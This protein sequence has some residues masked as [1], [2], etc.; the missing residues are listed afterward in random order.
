MICVGLLVW[1]TAEVAGQRPA[2]KTAPEF[3]ALL[4][5][6]FDLHQK[7]QYLRALPLLRRA[8]KLEPHEYFVNLLLGIDLLRTGHGAESVAFLKEAA[9]ANS[10]EETPHEYLG[11]A[12]AAMGHFAEAFE[13]YARAV[14]LAPQ[15]P[16]AAVPS[17][18]FCLARYVA[19]ANRL[20]SSNAGLAAEYRL[21]AMAAPLNDGERVTLL[22]RAAS[23]D[24]G[25]PGL[26]SELALTDLMRGD[27]ATGR[28]HLQLAQEH[29]PND[30]RSW[31]AAAL[32]AAI[33][34]DWTLAS[35]RLDAIYERSPGMLVRAVTDWP[36][37]LHPAEA[38]AKAGPGSVFL[39]CSGEGKRA[40]TPEVL[41]D[42]LEPHANTKM[43]PSGTPPNVLFREQR[44][45]RLLSLPEPA[46]AETEAWLHRGVAFAEL[47]DCGH[48]IPAL[49]HGL[50]SHSDSA[51]DMLLLSVCYARQA[52]SIAS[53][54]QELGG[55]DASLHMMR[56][57]ILLRLHAD[58]SGALAEYQAA[59]ARHG[60]DPD[61]LQ[62]LAEAQLGAGQVEPARETAQR[63]LHLDPHCFP[64]MRTLAKIAMQ[65]RNYAQALPYLRQ[66]VKVDPH[67]R[68]APTAQVELATACAQTGALEEAL[69]NLGPALQSGY[70]D[71]KG[72]LHFLLGT[73]LR[74]M[75]RA[76]Q[77]ERAFSQ[78]SKLSKDFQHG[79]R[80]EPHERP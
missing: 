17:V 30:L 8:W 27:V 24:E 57:D 28:Q 4:H 73:V 25:A 31:E 19:L 68:T 32:L 49:E 75:G 23:L 5:D 33:E 51:R 37:T 50:A 65:E 10:K 20:R 62:R 21:Q 43:S 74:R 6:A 36:D 60:S 11:E 56:G 46:W 52:G 55:D 35:T 54:L 58:S 18:D 13:S 38:S 41:L 34:K 66:L 29:D 80:Q 39:E 61:L 45:E 14:R 64:A 71:E 72:S 48:A 63:A 77:A 40:C 1:L 16:E 3:E 67:G 12:Q 22:M 9:R 15:T 44:W 69:Q 42:R 7:N 79:S 59:Q 76:D 47:G 2:P 70:P 78:A 26:W 53:R